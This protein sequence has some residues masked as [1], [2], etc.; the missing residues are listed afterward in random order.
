MIEMTRTPMQHKTCPECGANLD[1]GEVC[2]CRK[3]EKKAAPLH[4]E[5]PQAKET[6]IA[7]LSAR[8]PEVK[9]IGGAGIAEPLRELRTSKQ[10]PAKEMVAVVQELYPKY[11]KTMQSKCENGAEYGVT[12][13]PDAMDALYRKFDPAALEGR[14]APKKERH[15]LT[16]RISGRLETAEY[17]ALQLNMEADGYATVQDWITAMVREYNHK[18]EIADV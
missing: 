7:S 8:K 12:I 6:P 17:E 2:S 15:R 3:D 14:S 9:R 1:F 11:D 13:R 10:I 16:C 4:R 18:K 5:R